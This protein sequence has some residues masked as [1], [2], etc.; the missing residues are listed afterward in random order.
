MPDERPAAIVLDPIGGVS[1]DMFVAALLDAFPALVEPVLEA[2]RRAGLPPEV[3]VALVKRRSGGIAAAGLAFEGAL[4]APSGDYRAFRARLEAADLSAPIRRHALCI[5]AL[6][7]E[8]EAAIHAVPVDDVHFH[9]ISDWDTQ[10]DI[11]GA[12]AIV[13]ALGDVSWHCRPLPLGSGAVKAA[14]GL[15]PV[16]APAT[17]LLLKGFA[18]RAD[19][20]IAGERVT[21]TGAAILRYLAAANAGVPA[22]KLLATGTGAGTRQ[23]R[24]AP[25]ILRVLA[26]SAITQSAESILVVEFD[27]D[28]QSPE[29]TAIALDNLRAVAGVRDVATFQGLGKKGRWLQAVR[30]MAEP[31]ARDAVVEAI[32]SE[33]TT[34]GLRLREE[35]RVTLPRREVVVDSETGPTR[36]KLAERPT[37]ITAKAESDDVARAK[38]ASGRARVRRSAARRA[39]ESER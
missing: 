20:G 16:P 25:N 35:S 32:F 3:K 1:G 5:L 21:P 17:A 19:D 10:A 26:L 31:A 29:E 37:G 36:V 24:G 9:E 39:L 12:A 13:D 2:M 11:V 7:A 18:F 38:R 23:L 14:H 34:L 15:L 33:T 4:Q 6:L 27:V 28:D 22:G 8:A 30:V